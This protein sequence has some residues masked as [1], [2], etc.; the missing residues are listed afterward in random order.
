M[1]PASSILHTDIANPDEVC[2]SWKLYITVMVIASLAMIV[3]VVITALVVIVLLVRRKWRIKQELKAKAA[4]ITLDN[5]INP[6]DSPKEKFEQYKAIFPECYRT[7]IDGDDETPDS[8]RSQE[9][10]E[11]VIEVD[12]SSRIQADSSA[13]MI[14]PVTISPDWL[15]ATDKV[16]SRIQS[17]ENRKELMHHVLATISREKWRI[18]SKQSSV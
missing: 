1:T 10:I 14:P 6:S 5:F 8:Q 13:V 16:L 4:K 3:V 15:K 11:H 17:K 18:A 9:D 2:D 12:Q 7:F